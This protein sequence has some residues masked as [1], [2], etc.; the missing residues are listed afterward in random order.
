MKRE[1]SSIY[2]GLVLLLACVIY[3][4]AA[5][6]FPGPMSNISP[7][8]AVAFA[9]A[10]YLPRAW[11]WLIVPISLLFTELAFLSVN[12]LTDGSGSM[13]SW[14]TVIA[15]VIYVMAS[16][17]GLLIMNHKSLLKIIGGSLACSLL[18]YVVSNTFSWWHDLVIQMPNGYPATLA[19]W[20]QAN[21]VGLPA[22]SATPT[23][24]FLRNGMVGDL[25]FVFLLL[26]ILD[27]GF[28]LGQ[29]PAKT[30]ARPA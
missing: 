28:L 20:W 6:H 29:A 21:T 9:G 18:F 23:W 25:F 27:R 12:Y 2:L 17:L 1:L 3:R 4:V 13:F 7:L 16:G 10:M 11:G 24:M 8:M 22:Y 14:Y 5:S 15:L 19:G 30:T 26:F